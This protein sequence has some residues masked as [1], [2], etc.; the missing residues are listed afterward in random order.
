[1]KTCKLYHSLYTC[2]YELGWIRRWWWFVPV[3]VHERGRRKK[4]RRKELE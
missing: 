1:M 4:E 2:V 3:R